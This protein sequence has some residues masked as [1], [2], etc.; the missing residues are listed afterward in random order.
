M[1]SPLHPNI[2]LS[3]S[4]KK[5]SDFLRRIAEILIIGSCGLLPIIFI[6]S[7]Y[8]P[9]SSGK[10]I[11]IAIG[12][13]LGLL[14]YFLAVLKDGKIS[15]RL[16]LPIAGLWL[17]A[18]VTTVSAFLSGDRHDAFLGNS[19]EIY[20]AAFTILMAVLTT[21]MAVLDKGQQVI[22]LYAVIIGS[23]LVLSIFHIAS[24]IFGPEAV[25][26]GLWN[27]A[28]VSPIGSWNGL[29][30]FYGLVILLSLLALQQLPLTRAG[31][32]IISGIIGLSLFMLAVVNFSSVWWVIGIIA[33]IIV[34][35]HLLRNL[36]N[37]NKPNSGAT[38]SL[39][40]AVVV[41]LFSIVFLVGGARLGTLI[42]TPLGVDFVE[43]RP[44]ATATLEIARAVYQDNLWLGSG[45]N[46]FADSWR[47]H[48]DQSINQTIFWNTQFDSGYSYIFTS[49][50]GN[51]LLGF[52]AWCI[53][54][55]SLLWSGIKFVFNNN[56]DKDNFWHFIGVSSLAASI[57]FWVMCII[58]VPPPAILM[59]TAI[60]T[61]IF[62]MAH[63]K[64]LVSKTVNLSVEKNRSHGLVM[65]VM[66]VLV[67]VGSGYGVYAAGSHL[68]GVYEFNKATTEISEGDS[69]DD[70]QSRITSAFQLSHNDIFA[71]EIALYRLAE[72]RTLLTAKEPSAD[73]KESF[74]K[75]AEVSIQAAQSAINL[76]STDPYNYQV[77][78]QI[79]ATL[80]V[81]GVEGAKEKALETF[82][83]AK[84]Y[85]PHS[86]ITYLMEAELAI[87][88]DDKVAARTAAERAVVLRN[89]YTEALFLLAQLDIEEGNTERAIAI[90]QAI[91]QL[92]PENP[93]RRYQLGILL[94]S[95]DKL[96]EAIA[97]FEQAVALDPQ[98]ANARYFLALGYAEKG[99][100]DKAIEQLTIVKGLSEGNDMV[101]KLISQ[102][103]STG[104][105]DASLTNQ[106]PVAERSA[107][108]GD[109]VEAD[110]ENDLVTSS[111]PVP[112][113]TSEETP[114]VQ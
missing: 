15:L 60:T 46:R 64:S 106:S 10:T 79:Y 102:L 16:P 34:L 73:A 99:M 71:R 33:G 104:S 108:D 7:V 105:I 113:T 100:V 58:Y 5:S 2:V 14:F 85:D 27:S 25:S 39:I 26:F 94:A 31:R 36:W 12:V 69:L 76:D 109:V 110:L 67:V 9:L 103:Q 93:A 88:L 92:E 48:K 55:L 111:N 38:Y 61:G 49:I 89:G 32:Y 72:M 22:R 35:H 53:F 28:T 54:L 4:T 24:F 21:S 97:S 18:L 90:V 96:D 57:Y 44:S 112:E 23:G 43:V 40:A 29:A 91:T 41:L 68:A 45:P 1:S 47:L 75:A 80:A 52:L 65:I 13:A 50:I 70:I 11:F 66:V 82:Q 77:L 78:G 42:T 56:S 95:F 62:L 59:L 98:Y 30:I 6:P 86:P 17:I 84:Q 114:A 107:D 81:V 63:S 20:T 101:D 37:L 83:V 8:L 3:S 74:S 51:G 87:Q 19:I